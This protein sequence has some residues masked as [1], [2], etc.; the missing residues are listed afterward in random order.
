[1]ENFFPF[2]LELRCKLINLKV[3]KSPFK[4]EALNLGSDL[5]AGVC[6][7]LKDRVIYGN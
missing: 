4:S 2:H 5:E 3:E 6:V 1:M 7:C